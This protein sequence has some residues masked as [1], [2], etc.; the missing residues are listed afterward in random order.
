MVKTVIKI[1]S[2]DDIKKFQNEVLKFESDIDIVR[3]R[4][5]VDAKST[6]GIFTIDLST[7]IDVVLHTDDELE[8]NK[9]RAIMRQFQE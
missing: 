6:L 2:I 1:N 9:F 7:S 3:G 5:I 8:Q 4:Y